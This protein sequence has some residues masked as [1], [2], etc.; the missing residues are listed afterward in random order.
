[1]TRSAAY[2]LSTPTKCRRS[3][4]KCVSGTSNPVHQSKSLPYWSLNEY[5]PCDRVKLTS[6]AY[7]S[8]F[9]EITY[10]QHNHKSICRH[11]E[12][13]IPILPSLQRIITPRDR[14]GDEHLER[15][16]GRHKFYQQTADPFPSF[17]IALIIRSFG[18]GELSRGEGFRYDKTDH[19]REKQVV[20]KSVVE[21]CQEI[22]RLPDQETTECGSYGHAD[23]HQPQIN[24]ENPGPMCGISA[25]RDVG[26][27]IC[28]C[29]A[30]ACGGLQQG[31]INYQR[32]F[33]VPPSEPSKTGAIRRN[34]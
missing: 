18:P 26:V 31:R 23:I 7:H 32:D 1:M 22:A 29:G 9:E 20:R 19:A 28:R 6:K 10:H 5:A 13:Q 17:S 8:I 15:G 34:Q 25:I 33:D 14:D 12:G 3:C 30:H 4:D 11:Q 2:H 16:Q 24:R 27:N 21:D